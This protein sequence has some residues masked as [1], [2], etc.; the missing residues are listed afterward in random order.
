LKW[1]SAGDFYLDVESTRPVTLISGG[2]GITPMMS[3]L[4]TIAKV[5]PTRPVA[6]LH[7]ARNKALHAFDENVRQ[8]MST[9]EDTTYVALYSDENQIL[10]KEILAENVLPNSDVYICGPTPFMKAIIQS[11]YDLGFAEDHIHFEFFG[12]AVSL[13][14]V[15]A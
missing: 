3:M 15:H 8:L 7:G 10:T 14:L 4:D 5:S 13:N 2:V 9:M 1:C 6:F 11:L 12:P